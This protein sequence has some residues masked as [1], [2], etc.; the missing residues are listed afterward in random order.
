M[1]IAFILSSTERSNFKNCDLL[2]H[3]V[4][5]RKH[6]GSKYTNIASMSSNKF[7]GDVHMA[8]LP[9]SGWVFIVNKKLNGIL[10]ITL[11]H[12]KILIFFLEVA[13]NSEVLSYAS[14]KVHLCDPV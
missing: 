9:S 14:S 6:I 1:V 3:D 7:P 4:K 8:K 12:H 2:L 11:I 5:V 10:T 13:F